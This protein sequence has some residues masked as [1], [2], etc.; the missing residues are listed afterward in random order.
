MSESLQIVLRG[1]V[2]KPAAPIPSTASLSSLSFRAGLLS[3]LL[4][5]IVIFLA[6][7]SAMNAFLS[8]TFVSLPFASMWELAGLHYNLLMW[9]GGANEDYL[10]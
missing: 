7:R 3:V 6:Y 4:G 8:V 1:S 2:S 10:Q 5:E 9:E